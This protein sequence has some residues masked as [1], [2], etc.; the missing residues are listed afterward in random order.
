VRIWKSPLSSIPT[1]CRPLLQDSVLSAHVSLSHRIF[2]NQIS[3]HLR[4]S[5]GSFWWFPKEIQPGQQIFFWGS[6][7][8]Y[9]SNLWCVLWWAIWIV[10]PLEKTGGR[11]VGY[12]LIRKELNV[13]H[14]FCQVI[15]IVTEMHIIWFFQIRVDLIFDYFN[16]MNTLHFLVSTRNPL[17]DSF[18]GPDITFPV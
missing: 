8:D 16:Q 14:L 18:D 12:L 7:G 6:P 2:Q 11:T 13:M 9:R 15:M 4:H 10:P 17:K 3:T 5:P 1:S